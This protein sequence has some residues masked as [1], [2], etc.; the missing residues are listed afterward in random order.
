MTRL[1]AILL[2]LTLT[3]CATSPTGSGLLS[4]WTQRGERAAARA[5]TAHDAAREAQLVA[6]RVEAEKTAAAAAVLPKSSE[7]ELTQ[8][9]AGN[10]T[11]LLAQ[12]VPNVTAAQLATVRQLVADLRS[13]D[14]AIVAAAEAR[15]AKAERNNADLSRELAATAA[16]LVAADTRATE[17]AATNARLASQMLALK[18]AAGL[19][20]ALTIA[21]TLAAVAYRANA[22]GLADGVA[23]GLAD[24]RR[25]QPGVADLATGALDA[26]LNR[27]EQSK[28]ALLAQR[29][30]AAP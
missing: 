6:A 23:R 2:L 27:A 26:G 18:W 10:T 29:Y 13:G 9:F 7:A 21:S 30:L 24:L 14:A 11:D 3:G 12:A 19:G 1:A 20:T 5:D 15:Q 25:K 28:I 4:W 8:R 16:R 22:F 17:I